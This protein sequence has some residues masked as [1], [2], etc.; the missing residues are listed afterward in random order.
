M[1]HAGFVLTACVGG[2]QLSSYASF[3][4]KGDVAFSIL[5][6]S[7]TTIASVLITPLLTGRLV[8]SVV[9]VDA[10]AM[11]KSILQV[12][13][14]L[15]IHYVNVPHNSTWV[16][17]S[18]KFIGRW[19]FFRSPLVLLSTLMPNQ[20]WICFDQWCLWWPWFAPH[21]ALGV[22]LQSIGAKFCLRRAFIWCFQYW[23]FIQ[24]HSPWVTG[25][26]RFQF[27]GSPVCLN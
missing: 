24:C 18:L 1:F 23:H 17:H 2:A 27:S 22:L 7:S 13:S 12:V 14:G 8:G 10:V 9:P 4:S 11:S 5:L 20:L 15:W 26:P 6:T 3:L 19:F 16:A 25:S 21:C